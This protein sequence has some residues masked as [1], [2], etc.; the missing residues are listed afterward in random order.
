MRQ[1]FLSF[2][3]MTLLLFF[4]F[5]FELLGLLNVHFLKQFL[6]LWVAVLSHS[7]QVFNS[8]LI[9]G[10]LQKGLQDLLLVIL[11]L[12]VL[13][14]VVLHFVSVFYDLHELLLGFDIFNVM[15]G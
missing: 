7:I 8:I 3:M 12:F 4:C 15:E 9:F 6:I 2:L 10:K 1:V 13:W 14:R 5:L 11:V